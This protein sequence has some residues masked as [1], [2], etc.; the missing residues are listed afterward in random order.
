MSRNMFREAIKTEQRRIQRFIEP[1]D[2]PNYGTDSRMI[3]RL[4]DKIEEMFYGV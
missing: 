1:S 3:A 2:E 4:A